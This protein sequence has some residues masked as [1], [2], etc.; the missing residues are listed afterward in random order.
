MH[1]YLSP[2]K[3]KAEK[4]AKLFEEGF[5][6]KVVT[7]DGFLYPGP[8]AFYGTTA[9]TLPLIRQA[10]AMKK[11]WYYVDNA[12]Y[13]GRKVYYR[14]TKN[15]YMHS[16]EGDFPSDRLQRF[17]LVIESWRRNPNGYI[18]LT[19]QSDLFHEFQGQGNQKTWAEKT[20]RELRKFTDREIRVCYKPSRLP[21]G[22]PHDPTFEDQI[23]GA[24]A[25]VTD[26]S[27]TAVGALI[28]GVP[29]FAV[30]SCTM[31]PPNIGRSKIDYIEDPVYP[32][33]TWLVQWLANLAYNQW[34]Y[35]EIREGKCRRMINGV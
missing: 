15:R 16:G 26:S 12:Y 34:T 29:A 1:F 33:R 5:E 8:A 20:S 3:R 2:G 19:T 6:V 30:G 4:I 11:E 18:L 17:D 28:N 24:F 14:V 27:S 35:E 23:S 21:V 22:Y 7:A 10:I 32:N 13:F 25:L 31:V 9:Y